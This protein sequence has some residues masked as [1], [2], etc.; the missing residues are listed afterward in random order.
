MRVD[1]IDNMAVSHLGAVGRALEERGAHIR[2]IRAFAGD[3][4]PPAPGDAGAPDA[5]VVL[6]GE[7]NALA[8]TAHPY[9]PDLSRRMRDY[10]AAGKAVLGI[11]L[12][13]QVFARGLGAQN[14]IGGRTEFGWHTIRLSEAGRADPV[15]GAAGGEITSFQWHDDNF[16]IPPDAQAL[17]RSDIAEQAFRFGRAGYAMQFHFEADTSVVADWVTAF[18]GAIDRKSPGWQ[19]TYP[20]TAR[21]LGTRADRDGLSIARA[22]VAQI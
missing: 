10:A 18:P 7:Q 5:L 13:S 15:L 11:C 21:T 20:D 16:T 8:D 14:I 19:A 6:G 9:L 17:A 1:V 12:G 3:P 4:L 22:W 2:R